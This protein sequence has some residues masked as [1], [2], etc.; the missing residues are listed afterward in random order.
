MPDVVYEHAV[1][2]ELHSGAVRTLRGG[3]PS[4]EAA[5]KHP[6]DHSLWKRVWIEET[7]KPFEEPKPAELPQF[8][9]SLETSNTSDANGQF[10]A[11][12]VDA[13]GKKFAAL[14]G[15]GHQKTLLAEHILTHCSPSAP[16]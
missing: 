11:Y 12:L 13:N 10:H 1:K 16:T 4:K 5:E 6:V 2:A 14:W 15:S 9:W 7:G 8:P 3:F